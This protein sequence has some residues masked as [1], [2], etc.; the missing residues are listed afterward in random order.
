MNGRPGRGG[1]ARPRPTCSTRRVTPDLPPSSSSLAETAAADAAA[2]QAADPHAPHAHSAG[3]TH[4]LNCGTQLTGPYCS[5]CGQHDFDFHRSFGHV[6]LE[7]L[8]NIFHFDGKFFRNIITLLFRPGKLTAEFNAG[9]RASQVPPFRLYIFTAFFFFVWVHFTTDAPEAVRLGPAP[10]S[11]AQA[12]FTVD[13]VPVTVEQA[14]KARKDPAYAEE[15]RRELAARGAT[16]VGTAS[17]APERF[18]DQIRAAGEELRQEAR[19]ARPANTPGVSF[20]PSDKPESERSD[21]ER[22]AEEKGRRALDPAFQRE[23]GEAFIAALPKMLLF[24]MPVFAL[25]TRLLYRKS[26]QVYLQHLII[27]LHFHTFIFLWAMFRE[28][29]ADFFGLLNFTTVRGWLIL[30]AN[31]W[32]VLYPLLMLRR[33]FGQSWVRTV[34]KTLALT[35]AYILTLALAFFTTGVILILML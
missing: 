10:A 20:R 2:A 9:K 11:G 19:A 24:C 29:W 21:F 30:A 27:A 6:F 23:I 8:E 17:A 3:H 22:W 34:V 35:F 31:C 26:G 32:I 1:V 14:M 5:A 7:A 15:L 25:I 13:D 28:G 33:L 4:C 16:P 18:V 12:T